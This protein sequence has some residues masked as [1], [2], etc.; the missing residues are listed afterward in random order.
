MKARQQRVEWMCRL[1]VLQC[2][3][4]KKGHQQNL[5]LLNAVVALRMGG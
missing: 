4:E 1:W 3:F 2:F 5:H